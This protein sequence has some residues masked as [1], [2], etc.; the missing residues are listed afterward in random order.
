MTNVL[1]TVVTAFFI[2]SQNPP[3]SAGDHSNVRFFSGWKRVGMRLQGRVL[4]SLVKEGAT[5][6]QVIALLGKDKS[7]FK[8]LPTG[9]VVGVFIWQDYIWYDLG[10]RVTFQK[11]KDGVMR[12]G[13]IQFAPVF[14]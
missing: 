13:P 14:D 3:Q 12:A 5:R 7:P 9:G 2:G 11:A 1:L 4:G 8:P 10:L 6:D